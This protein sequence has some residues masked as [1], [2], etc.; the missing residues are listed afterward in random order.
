MTSFFN[1]SLK[2]GLLPVVLAPNVIADLL[3]TLQGQK[4]KVDLESQTVTLP[5]GAIQ[6]FEVDPFARHCLLNGIDELDYTLS[7]M[8][9]ITGFERTYE[10][11]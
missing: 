7:L 2:N 6:R 9:E 8:E 10:Q 5:E 11:K 3:P 1:N 4:L